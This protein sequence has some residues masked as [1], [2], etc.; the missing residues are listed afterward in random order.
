MNTNIP[1]ICAAC[2]NV[3]SI[4]TYNSFGGPFCSTCAGGGTSGT[5]EPCLS[6]ASKD[7]DLAALRS[8]LSSAETEIAELRAWKAEAIRRGHPWSVAATT[9]IERLRGALEPFAAVGD[10]KFAGIPIDTPLIMVGGSP[11]S[12]PCRLSIG[13]FRRAA[14]AL[15]PERETGGGK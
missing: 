8:Q 13:D 7:A 9:E 1:T 3:A 14:A 6:C 10:S 5:P 4:W 12:D 11:G 15:R 2:G